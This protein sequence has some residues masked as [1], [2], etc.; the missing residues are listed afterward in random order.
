MPDTCASS[1]L[2]DLRT[3]LVLRLS[4]QDCS[5]IFVCFVHVALL[6]VQFRT[7]QSSLCVKG[8]YLQRGRAVSDSIISG[9]KLA[10][11]HCT[12]DVQDVAEPE[13]IVRI[14]F[15]RSRITCHCIWEFAIP[16]FLVATHLLLELRFRSLQSTFAVG[17]LRIS[18]QNLFEVPYPN[19]FQF[20]CTCT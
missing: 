4:F 5:I 13:G 11:H 8:I 14:K 7:L 18:T 1:N 16:E 2:L 17:M 9:S 20:A 10:S 15:Q 6:L 19:S 12:V 3:L